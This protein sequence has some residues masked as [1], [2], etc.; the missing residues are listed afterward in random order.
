MVLAG[1]SARVLLACLT[2]AIRYGAQRRQFGASGQPESFILDYPLHQFRLMPYLAMVFG[3]NAASRQIV[4]WWGEMRDSLF[5]PKNT[6]LTEVHAIISSFKSICTWYSFRGIQECREA[7]GGHGYNAISLIGVHRND[8]DISQTWEGDNNVLL[9]QTS[10]YIAD[11]GQKLYKGKKLNSEVMAF[12]DVNPLDDKKAALG[13]LDRFLD[14][15][16]FPKLGAA[17]LKAFE[18]R[19]NYLLQAAGMKIAGKIGDMKPL[20]AWND[21]QPFY[22]RDMAI[23]FGEMLIVKFHLKDVLAFSFKDPT[24]QVG[25]SLSDSDADAEHVPAQ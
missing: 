2:I 24:N 25:G 22:M 3:V 6:R 16:Q 23:A 14:G 1:I 13:D 11:C 12:L 21:T 19:V 9:Q 4:S 17:V 7:C 18:W 15:A 5:D 8:L 20:D 10:K